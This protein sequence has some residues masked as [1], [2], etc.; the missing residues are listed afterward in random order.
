MQNTAIDLRTTQQRTRQGTLRTL[1]LENMADRARPR[2][3]IFFEMI[4]EEDVLPPNVLDGFVFGTI[5]GAMRLA[6]DVRVHGPVSRDALLNLNE[7][8]EAWALWKPQTYKK[9][10]II[11]LE[12]VDSLPRPAKTEAIAAFSGGVDSVFTI[13]RHNRKQLGNASYPLDGCV[14]MVHGFDVPL[15][16]PQHLDALKNR[17][18]PLLDELNLKLLTIRTNLK[19]VKLQHWEDSF[20]PQLAC[21]LHNYSHRFSYGVA[22][23]S[24]PYDA[25]VLPWG[26]NPAT[27]HLLS[28]AAMRI[29]HDGAGYSRTEKVAQ[30]A[31]HKTATRVLKVCW[32][33]HETFK[34]C[35]HCEKCIRTQLNFLAAGISHAPCFDLPFDTEKISSVPLPSDVQYAELLS[36]CK[37]AEAHGVTGHWM[38]MLRARLDAYRPPRQWPK[39]LE[40]CR[41]KALSI[42]RHMNKMA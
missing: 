11:P 38:H 6:Q 23:S 22:G 28:G 33:G 1:Y 3:E 19:A 30:I 4:G 14:L 24:E 32:Q 20:M 27:D 25:L 18:K 2:L 26:S 8:Q 17:T 16:L 37:Y 36:I 13:L 15:D 42:I 10:Q 34:N 39:L 31:T 7:F 29:V 12:I 41:R 9:V 21:C 40:K 35:G 5:M